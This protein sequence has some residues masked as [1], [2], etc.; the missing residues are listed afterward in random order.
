MQASRRN[1]EAFLS[2]LGQH[3]GRRPAVD[4]LSRAQSGDQ[5]ALGDRCTPLGDQ[6]CQRALA[7]TR[8]REARHLDASLGHHEGLAGFHAL[9]IA[10]E[11]LS[12]L[13]HTHR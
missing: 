11:V 4:A 1:S 13:S 3:I 7:I 5:I 9:Q 10:A 2:L 12:Q 6:A 8:R